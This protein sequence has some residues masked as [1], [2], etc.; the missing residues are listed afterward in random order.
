MLL[1]S[2]QKGVRDFSGYS[3]IISH[4]RLNCKFRRY[5]RNED[6]T[7]YNFF[8]CC[9]RTISNPQNTLTAT[10][11]SPHALTSVTI[12]DQD[13]QALVMSDDDYQKVQVSFG[14]SDSLTGCE[15]VADPKYWMQ[16]PIGFE[17]KG[18]LCGN[19]GTF[20]AISVSGLNLPPSTCA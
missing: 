2:Q 16:L 20:L 12:W 10:L 4:L 7:S 18:L 5:E 11:D 9:T 14:S 17:R 13:G 19:V 15:V 1:L 3:V 6:L 8:R